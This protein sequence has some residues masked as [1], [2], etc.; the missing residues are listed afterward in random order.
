MTD[1]VPAQTVIADELSDAFSDSLILRRPPAAINRDFTGEQFVNAIKDGMYCFM[2]V[3]ILGPCEIKAL[4]EH[5]RA[6]KKAK[7][8]NKKLILV[9]VD[10]SQ[11]GFL[12]E[13]K[14]D[15]NSAYHDFVGEELYALLTCFC[16]YSEITLN[17]PQKKSLKSLESYVNADGVRL[18]VN[19]GVIDKFLLDKPLASEKVPSLRKVSFGN[20]IDDSMR[21]CTPPRLR[22]PTIWERFTTAFVKNIIHPI[23]KFFTENV[24]SKIK[25]FFG[26]GKKV[27]HAKQYRP[28]VT[29][30]PTSNNTETFVP[31]ISTPV[32]ES[33]PELLPSIIMLEEIPERPSALTYQ[34]RFAE[35][36]QVMKEKA[37]AREVLDYERNA[38]DW[39]K[40]IA[41]E[42]IIEKAFKNVTKR[43][44]AAPRVQFSLNNYIEKNFTNPLHF[45]QQLKE[46]KELV[47][48]Y[49]NFCNE[50]CAAVDC[51][52]AKTKA[53]E[54]SLYVRTSGIG[55]YHPQFFPVKTS[56][57]CELH[58]NLQLPSLK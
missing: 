40:R 16:I 27:M 52:I 11:I 5:L 33:L 6:L 14:L 34:M 17:A 55:M 54:E 30:T 23:K 20:P 38:P 22:A 41:K 31:S 19:Y 47:T 1:P 15:S 18:P 53:M 42:E 50:V 57:A 37:L 7:N 56:P 10:F 13:G 24:F 28:T 8:F 48:H 43:S 45:I 4:M 32:M 25:S 49:S 3:R 46:M 51:V 36:E 9:D 29:T 21:D 2:N 58:T 35:R 44:K 39:I 26:F 12:K